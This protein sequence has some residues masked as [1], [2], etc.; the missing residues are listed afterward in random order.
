MLV[1]P[2]ADVLAMVTEGLDKFLGEGKYNATHVEVFAD[3]GRV[4]F[5]R[6]N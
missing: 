4:F 2:K 1:L 5:E 6:T 3:T